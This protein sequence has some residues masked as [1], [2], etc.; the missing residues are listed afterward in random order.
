MCLRFNL[1]HC[2]RYKC[3]LQLDLRETTGN[4]G[5][6]TIFVLLEQDSVNICAEFIGRAAIELITVSDII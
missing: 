1:S 2:V 4:S 5:N 3:H 6:V